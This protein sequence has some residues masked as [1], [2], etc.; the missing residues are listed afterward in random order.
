[1]LRKSGV[2]VI[3]LLVLISLTVGSVSPAN[4]ISGK[5]GSAGISEYRS[6]GMMSPL[7]YT[8]GKTMSPVGFEHI[9]KFTTVTLDM[10]GQEVVTVEQG[11]WDPIES[12]HQPGVLAMPAFVERRDYIAGRMI[13]QMAGSNMPQ[14]FPV[15]FFK[16]NDNGTIDRPSFDNYRANVAFMLNGSES[17]STSGIMIY[18]PDGSS[19]L[20][21]LAD[22]IFTF[23]GEINVPS[24]GAQSVDANS[25]PYN[26]TIT[27][28]QTVY[29][30]AQVAGGN[31]SMSFD[32][33]WMNANDDLRLSV[34]TPDGHVL[35]PY[36]DS[37]DGKKD[38]RINLEVDNPSGV[39]GGTWSFKVTGSNVTGKDEYY[40][41]TW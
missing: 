32:L 29:H 13:V 22:A 3:L 19:P 11:P 14:A 27:Q 28:G 9:N 36:T 39:S 24:A 2:A 6:S 31:T 1:M 30:Q 10:S 20:S 35:G 12:D 15:K 23:S 18:S 38:G 5:N 4:V 26:N 17:G 8:Y 34:Y 25:S 33:K 7:L 16:H 21:D 37:S 41:R 40:L